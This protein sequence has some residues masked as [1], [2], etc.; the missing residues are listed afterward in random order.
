M[1]QVYTNK[2]SN[3]QMNEILRRCCKI[4]KKAINESKL[5]DDDESSDNSVM[6]RT[7]MSDSRT[8]EPIDVIS[9]E[10]GEMKNTDILEY[11]RDHYDLPRILKQNIDDFIEK[12]LDETDA[13]DEVLRYM[14]KEILGCVEDDTGIQIN[15]VL[16]LADEDS[17]IENYE[18]DEKEIFAYDTTDGVILSDLGYDGMLWGFTEEPEPIND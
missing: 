10:I 13:D 2:L 12:E 3:S 6:F 5:F 17:V 16:W 7:E 11:C 9:F 15:Y 8:E 14:I 4:V 1:K 18:G